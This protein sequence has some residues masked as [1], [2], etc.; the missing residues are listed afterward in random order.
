[1]FKIMAVTG[2]RPD[3]LGGYNN[4]EKLTWFASCELKMKLPNLV[5]TGMALGWDQA[6]A[7]ACILLDI[8]FIAAVPFKGQEKIWPIA[9]QKLYN[10]LLSKADEINIICDGGYAPNKM[11]I[12]NEWMVD[13]CSYLEALWNG[14][15]GGTA[16][17]VKYANKKKVPVVNCWDNWN[18][19]QI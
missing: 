12:R 3:K 7:K 5:I 8:P 13:H 15:S 4:F 18:A 17:C 14:T 16:N 11:Q 2:H 19:S 9:S 6:I 10:E 1:M